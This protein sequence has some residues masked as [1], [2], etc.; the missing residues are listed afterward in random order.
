[1]QTAQSCSV[2]FFQGECGSFSCVR[3]R[4]VLSPKRR[5]W[6][7]QERKTNLMFKAVQ[8]T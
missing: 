4:G 2:P 8:S 6:R 7:S 5:I 3:L 1:M